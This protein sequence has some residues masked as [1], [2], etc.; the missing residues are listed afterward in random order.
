MDCGSKHSRD[1]GSYTHLL[2]IVKNCVG[3]SYSIDGMLLFM[4]KLER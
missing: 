2:G 3:Y 1:L 4:K